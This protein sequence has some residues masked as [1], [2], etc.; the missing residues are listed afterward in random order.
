M[1]AA[2]EFTKANE[3]YAQSFDKGDLPVPPGRRVAVVTCMDARLP[4]SRFLGLEEGDAH[5]IR[6]AGGLAKDALRSLVISQRLLGTNE[7]V[8]IHH[9]GCGMLTFQNGDVAAKVRDD[10]GA[11]ASGIDFMPFSDLDQSVR[12]DVRFLEE[13]P[14]IG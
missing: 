10:L 3:S 6:N 9:T 13:S 1:S 8:V 14:L 12:D 5:V 4:P 2:D 11:D 7:V